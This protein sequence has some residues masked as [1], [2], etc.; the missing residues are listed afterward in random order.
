[1]V[2]KYLYVIG[3]LILGC[4]STARDTISKEIPVNQ[5]QELDTATFA[6]GCFWCVEAAFEQIEGVIE[7]VSGYAD[8]IESTA[9]YRAVSSGRTKHSEAVQVYFNPKVID[10]PTLVDILFTA[11]DPTQLNRQGNDIGPQYR[12]AIYYH[13]QSQ[14]SIVE[15]KIKAWQPKFDKDIV[16]E[17]T[18]LGT[19][20]LAEE[21]HQD[22]QKKNPFQPYILAVSKPKA[23]K[24]REKF[25]NRLKEDYQ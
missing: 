8:G 25:K 24:V 22:Y 19:F 20:F 6:G 16:T 18:P 15:E 21:Y 17:V 2:M 5:N 13:D 3:V 10:Y 4:Q 9:N 14:K 7:V 23:K 11:H 12:S 1:M